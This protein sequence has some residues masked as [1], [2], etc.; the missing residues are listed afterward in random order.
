LVRPSVASIV[1]TVNRAARACV[2]PPTPAKTTRLVRLTLLGRN[3]G[4]PPCYHLSIQTCSDLQFFPPVS[5]GKSILTMSDELAS[6][7]M[8]G[9]LRGSVSPVLAPVVKGRTA[10]NE[11]ME[12]RKSNLAGSSEPLRAELASMPSQS[13]MRCWAG[14][15]IPQLLFLRGRV[16]EVTVYWNCACRVSWN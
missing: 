4:D 11:I 1:A 12:P 14:Q 13:T 7:F 8:L 5:C 10:F 15:R 6:I 3:D 2:E 9:R 16:V